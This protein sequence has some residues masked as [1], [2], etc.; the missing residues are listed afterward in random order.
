MLRPEIRFERADFGAGAAGSFEVGYRLLV[1]REKP[2]GRPVFGS[3][4]GDRGAVRDRKAGRAYTEKLDELADHLFPAQQLGQRQH[5][6]GGR[7]AAAQLSLEFDPDHVRGQKV[8]RLAQHRCL[9]LDAADAPAD[10]AD[11]VDHGGVAVGSDQRIRKVNAIALVHPARQVLQIDLVH[12]PE[13]GRHHAECA[14]GLHTPFH[15]LVTLPVAL[16]FQLHV[17]VQRIGRSIVV[18]HHR[19]VHHQV[20]RHQRLDQTRLTPLPRGGASHGRQIGQQR[21]AG[22]IL[23]NDPRDHERN[24]LAATGARLPAGQLSHVILGDFLAVAVAQDRLE[25]QTNRMGQA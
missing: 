6:I 25:P 14:E 7:H 1:D 5:Q 11:A 20:H 23:Q 12:D 15:E 16:E 13:A 17:Q 2:H 8:D 10:H 4:V 18:D 24:F 3:H 22:E 19:V 21:N 9:G